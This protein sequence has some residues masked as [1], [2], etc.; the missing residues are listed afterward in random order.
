MPVP[1]QTKR[2]GQDGQEKPQPTETFVAQ[3][4]EEDR[5][6]ILLQKELY[7]GSWDAM[8][9][10]LGN[11]LEGKPYIF[12]LANRIREDIARIEKLRSYESQHQVNLADFVKEPHH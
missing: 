12:K 2:G 11:R 3:L 10:D 7:Q 6:L 4:A 5:M 8:Q 1:N 9:T